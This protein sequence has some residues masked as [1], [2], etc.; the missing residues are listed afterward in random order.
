MATYLMRVLIVGS[1][2][3]GKTSLLVRFNEDKFVNNQRTTI[4]VDYKAKEVDVGNEHVKMQIW[5][6]A[7]Q[8]RFR[9]MTAAFYNKAQG[10]IL[11]FD[12]CQ[13]DSFLALPNWLEDIRRDAPEG[14]CILLCAN[15]CDHPEGSWA[16]SRIEIE[17]YCND[18]KLAFVET[19]GKTGQNVHSLFTTLGQQV[20]DRGKDR[21][22]QVRVEPEGDS[23]RVIQEGGVL[24]DLARNQKK[25]KKG[26]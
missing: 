21:L 23:Y 20:L 5:D 11:T 14:C 25:Q 24:A 10:V 6:T 22:Q 13:K 2:D 3:V 1:T 4:G 7:G 19:S 18:E 8:E 16:T 9:S 12:V 17:S 15:K 26:C